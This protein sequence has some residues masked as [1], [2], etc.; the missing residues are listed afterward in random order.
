MSLLEE[1]GAGECGSQV[2]LL[3]KFLLFEESFSSPRPESGSHRAGDV[4]GYERLSTIMICQSIDI[5]HK[6][7]AYTSLGCEQCVVPLE[8]MMP[9][10]LNRGIVLLARCFD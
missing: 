9:Q 2:L 6:Y 3:L 10:P 5:D 7:G 4:V 1:G 8:R